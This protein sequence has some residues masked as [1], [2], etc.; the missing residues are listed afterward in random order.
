VIRVIWYEHEIFSSCPVH[1]SF[2]PSAHVLTHTHSLTPL[3]L[4]L[5]TGKEKVETTKRA[6]KAKM[7]ELADL[8]ETARKE[9]EALRKQIDDL[10][11]EREILNKSLVK[12]GDKTRQADDLVRG[13]GGGMD[14]LGAIVLC[15]VHLSESR[16]SLSLSLSLC[17]YLCGVAHIYLYISL[18]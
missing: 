10:V 14:G 12:A 17:V 9:G 15:F 8:G 2:L 18:S 1:H 3:Y 11:R 5:D 6:H 16:S 4:Q 7:V 13:G